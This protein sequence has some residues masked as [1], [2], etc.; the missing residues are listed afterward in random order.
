MVAPRA[1][2]QGP[3]FD[4][5]QSRNFNGNS[6]A[7]GVVW[8]F[9]P[10][11]TLAVNGAYTERA[12]TYY[13]L[14]ANGPHA[15]TGVYET[16]NTAFGKEKSKTPDVTLRMKSGKHSGS[17]GVFQNHFDNYITLINTVSTCGADGELNPPD[18]GD[19][20]SLNT[21]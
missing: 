13:E 16:G 11:L 9:R 10:G 7:L 20:K 5:A 6:G 15:T 14:Y 17:V 3:R 1:R 8:N 2:E 18:A 4:P 19:G 21:G 12:P